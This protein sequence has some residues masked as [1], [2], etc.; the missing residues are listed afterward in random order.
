MR[1]LTIG[2]IGNVNGALSPDG[3]AGLNLGIVAIGA[4][5]LAAGATAPI[6]LPLALMTVSIASVV[7]MSE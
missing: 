3:T 1:S 4:G 6:W 5:I 7:F 2:E